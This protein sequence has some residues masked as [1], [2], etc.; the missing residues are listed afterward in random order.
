V[1]R[2]WTREERERFGAGRWPASAPEPVARTIGATVLGG[3]VLAVVAWWSTWLAVGAYVLLLLTSVAVEV[4]G[5]SLADR[6]T[7]VVHRLLWVLLRPLYLVG[8][9]LLELFQIG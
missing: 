2:R 8:L 7:T 6:A 4:G 1:S 3:M 5:W 9:T